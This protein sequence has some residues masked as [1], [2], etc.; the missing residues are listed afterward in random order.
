VLNNIMKSGQFRTAGTRFKGD[1]WI[2]RPHN[3]VT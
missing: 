1:T 3:I 2:L